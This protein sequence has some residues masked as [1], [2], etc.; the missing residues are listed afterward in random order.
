MDCRGVP[1][2]CT[3]ALCYSP[4]WTAHTAACLQV[5][6]R[7]S[8]DGLESFSAAVEATGFQQRHQ[9]SSNK[10]FVVLE[11]VRIG[12]AGGQDVQWPELLPCLY[13]HR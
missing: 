10:M 9:D 1:W 2:A 12:E 11:F 4:W 6:S 13:K 7:F 3:I 8:E 5:R